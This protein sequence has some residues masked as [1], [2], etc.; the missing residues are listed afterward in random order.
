MKHKHNKMDSPEVIGNRIL[1]ERLRLRMTQDQLSEHLGC[2]ANYLG[3]LERGTKTLSLSMA[4]RICYFFGISYDYLLL[5]KDT[6]GITIKIGENINFGEESGLSRL[7]AQC[8][9]R[10]QALCEKIVEDVLITLRSYSDDTKN[11]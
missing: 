1:V 10:E 6:S 4:E 11:S 9:P 2:T 5:G 7:L 8:S 3:Q